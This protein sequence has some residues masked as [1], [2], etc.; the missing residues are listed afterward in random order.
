M[1]RKPRK[2]QPKPTTRP[3]APDR[4]T[5]GGG[6]ATPPLGP[7]PEG[8]GP[9]GGGGS[10][11]PDWWYLHL[12]QIQPIR[13]VLV[14]GAVILLLQIGYSLRIVTIPILVA[15][16]LA[17]LFEPLIKRVT[18]RNWVSRPG[19]ALMIIFT[20]AVLV[21]VPLTVGIGF[22]AVQ[23]TQ[24]ARSLATNIGLVNQAVERSED[25]AEMQEA[26]DRLPNQGWR[27]IAEYFISLKA[28][29][30]TLE[31]S[32]GSPRHP[33]DPTEGQRT[34]EGAAREAT[35]DPGADPHGPRT[36]LD[37]DEAASAEATAEALRLE[38]R[39]EARSAELELARWVTNWVE[40]HASEISQQALATGRGAVGLALGTVTSVGVFLFQGFLAA[41]FFYFFSTGWGKVQEFWQSLIP[42]RRR[43]VVIDL[44]KKMDAVI[45]GFI[46]GR[47]L[48]G[49][50]LSAYFTL[51]Y[52]LIGVPAPLVIG[53]VTG[54]L[55][56]VPYLGFISIPMSIIAI[57][58]APSPWFAF[59]TS[60]WWMIFAP[61]AFYQLGQILDDYILTPAI[62]GKSTDMDV[63]SI[64]FATIAGGALA[65]VYGLLLAIPA[66][67]CLKILLREIFWPRFRRW[68][69]GKEKDFL[70]LD[71]K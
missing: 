17:Y 21:V 40:T 39:R 34:G 64:L 3:V 24:L 49:V 9:A 26:L 2:P 1:P 18:S 15:M 58:L 68:A 65:G 27:S 67:A 38:R 10:S 47:M 5:Q 6:G 63:P 66:A 12:W 59:Q 31:E 25:T 55:C 29:A 50:I 4:P 69:T 51:A 33:P 11:R 30:T 41:F 60:W 19:M 57:W 22:A 70:P 56:L 13:D 45:A 28:E 16:M 23:G 36:P 71:Q 32:R 42:E 8:A 53:P 44:L 52:W 20:A 61:I 46:R 35:E 54:L 43:G 48:I 62:Q 7:P 37:E 14:I